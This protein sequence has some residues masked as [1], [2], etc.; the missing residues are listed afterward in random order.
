M[1]HAAYLLLKLKL[2]QRF[3]GHLEVD[4]GLAWWGVV[5][6]C[7]RR[8]QQLNS[9]KIISCLHSGG[10]ILP[11]RG[12]EEASTIVCHLRNHTLTHDSAFGFGC[13]EGKLHLHARVCQQHADAVRGGGGCLKLKEKLGMARRK[14]GASSIRGGGGGSTLV[15]ALVAAGVGGTAF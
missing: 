5:R 3:N 2:G 15:L 14:G 6:P 10:R 4:K 8:I 13:A 11:H 9:S 12:P 1:S 7:T